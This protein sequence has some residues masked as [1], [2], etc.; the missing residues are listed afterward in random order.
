M[1]VT[2]SRQFGSDGETI[3]RAAAERLGL[4]VIDRERVRATALKAGIKPEALQRLMYEGQRTVAGEILDGLGAAKPAGASSNPLLGVFAPSTSS[5][6]VGLEEA[7]RGIGDVI[8]RLAGER[9]SLVLGQGSQALLRGAP[10]TCHVL[11]VAPLEYRI[12]NAMRWHN[13]KEADAR[14]S[15]RAHD[16]ARKDYLARYHNVRWLDPL[17]YD[18]VVNTER[19]PVEV[20]V[21]LVVAAARGAADKT[22]GS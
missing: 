19:V 6:T 4:A 12:A 9:D 2:V 7:A 11:F 1:I 17:L 3:A 5:G 10:A 21:G 14:R 15:I 8:R 20:A 22:Q 18:L 16:E 13:L